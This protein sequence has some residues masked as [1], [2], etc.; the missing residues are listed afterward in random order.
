MAVLEMGSAKGNFCLATKVST[1]AQHVGKRPT[2]SGA[3]R[4]KKASAGLARVT[5]VAASVLAYPNAKKR[6][7]GTRAAR[8]TTRDDRREAK[9]TRADH[10]EF[11]G[12]SLGE[13]TREL[14]HK[15][16]YGG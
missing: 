1:M 9:A 14:R 16:L 3:K 6:G 12:P 10:A 4:G 13:M 8:E 2:A 7:L 15:L 5:R 11:S